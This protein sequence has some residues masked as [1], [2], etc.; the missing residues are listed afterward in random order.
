MA[1]LIGVRARD[2]RGIWRWHPA[3]QPLGHIPYELKQCLN[4]IGLVALMAVITEA[5]EGDR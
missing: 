1:R 5:L 4:A 3:P 2:W